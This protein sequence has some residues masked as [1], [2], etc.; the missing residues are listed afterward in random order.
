M[1]ITTR[2]N[3]TWPISTP[4]LKDTRPVSSSVCGRPISLST[5][6]NPRPC[7][8][9]KELDTVIGYRQVKLCLG[10]RAISAARNRTL[11]AITASIGG[12]GNVTM[13]S[14]A[15]TRVIECATVNPVIVTN[16][17]SVFRAIKIKHNTK[18]K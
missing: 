11:N 8:N 1:S 10:P 12:T 9:P 4:I 17:L 3:I 2:A 7:S 16:I 14:A 15:S 5:A 13:S 18:S 6:A